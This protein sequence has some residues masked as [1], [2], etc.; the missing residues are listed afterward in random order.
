MH[1]PQFERAQSWFTPKK[2]RDI[3]REWHARY[4]PWAYQH[5]DER[6]INPK[7]GKADIHDV[8]E[9]RRAEIAGAVQWALNQLAMHEP[10]L[11][12]VIIGFYLDVEPK[13]QANRPHVIAW[14]P[15]QTVFELA[16]WQ[17]ITPRGIYMREVR[18]RRYMAELLG[19]KEPETE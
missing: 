9:M 12:D 2:L 10:A 16:E 3:L 18:A 11:Y 6:G 1:D 14:E 19:W 17:G 8:A 13:K 7:R 15:R 5:P 4:E